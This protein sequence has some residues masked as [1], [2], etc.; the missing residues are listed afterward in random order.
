M[1]VIAIIGAGALGGALAHKLA[2]RGRVAEIRLIDGAETIARGKALDILQ[3]GPVEGFATNLVAHGSILAATGA[4]VVVLADDA[5]GVEHAGEPALMLVRQLVQAGCVAPLLFAGVEQRELM[6]RA[7]TELR[8]PV[9]RILGSA[10]HALAS[11]VRAICALVV[12]ASPVDVS[13][14]VV[15]VP[16]R[17][18]VVAWEG[19][20][21]AGR[22]LREV[23]GA[24]EIAAVAA[25]IPGLWP[26]GPYALGSAGA[27]IAEALCAGSRREF[28]CYVDAGRGRIAALPVRIGRGGI[29]RVLEPALTSQER[30]MLENA[31]SISDKR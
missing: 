12:D 23:M 27:R 8:V 19:G 30:T 16:P 13:L 25:R 17:Q 1:S 15:G 28:S 29:D 20:S 31:L 22:P 7:V 4:D 26:P 2:G 5:A 3:S 24:H 21:C 10:P 11:A 14:S 6:W 18:A 9:P